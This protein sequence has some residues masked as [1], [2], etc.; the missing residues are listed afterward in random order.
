VN[1]AFIFNLVVLLALAGAASACSPQGMESD[2]V[3]G[4]ESLTGFRNQDGTPYTVGGDPRLI[5]E[6]NSPPK[7]APAPAPARPGTDAFKLSQA[8]VAIK[9]QRFDAQDRVDRFGTARTRV[10]FVIDGKVYE[11]QAPLTAGGG[12]NRFFVND[13]PHANEPYRINVEFT[14][15]ANQVH[16]AG[17][18]TVIK[19]DG[20]KRPVT[21][22]EVYIRSYAASVVAMPAMDV[23]LLP[24]NQ[25]WMQILED[26]SFAWVTNKVVD[27]ARSFYE[28]QVWVN[29]KNSSSPKCSSEASKIVSGKRLFSFA[30]ESVRTGDYGES[31]AERLERGLLVP[32]KISLKGDAETLD[33]RTF[34][35][36]LEGFQKQ[37]IDLALKI[38]KPDHEHLPQKPAT[39]RGLSPN[40]YFMVRYIEK[41][42]RERYPEFRRVSDM[43]D[44][45]EKNYELPGVKS[46]IREFTS[47]PAT[48]QT[49]LR[50]AQPFR[51]LI[52]QIFNFYQVAS[53]ASLV[54]MIESAFF[55]RDGYPLEVNA[56]ST[57]TGPFQILYDTAVSLSMRAFPNK[58]GKMP[59]GSDERLYFVPSACGAAKHFSRSLDNFSRHDRTLSILAYYQGDGGAAKFMQRLIPSKDKSGNAFKDIARYRITYRD[60]ERQNMLPRDVRH[61]VNRALALYF[62]TGNPSLHGFS[63]KEEPS[64]ALPQGKVMPKS[65]LGDPTCR[66]AIHP[67]ILSKILR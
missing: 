61:Y 45:F 6:N 60:I 34:K 64:A 48:L 66:E 39:A 23:N 62:V 7:P 21:R 53:P 65:A 14:D 67:L 30:G 32:L 40:A 52:N 29:S 43:I 63:W 18:I 41:K 49:A 58:R 22:A 24:P 35:V 33:E 46:A 2:S 59:A 37:N 9:V 31:E 11:F 54:L 42:D 26:R 13:V 47:N 56:V 44:D 25:C 12:A 57:A 50:N 20:R 38:M 55:K 28:V 10:Q 16:S 19:L 4:N 36:L 5:R 17:K 27:H 8:I 15:D 3:E 51:P 1:K